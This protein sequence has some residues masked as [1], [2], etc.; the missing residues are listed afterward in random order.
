MSKRRHLNEY[1][2][3]LDRV[4]KGERAIPLDDPKNLGKRTKF[5]G[6]AQLDSRRLY[7]GVPRVRRGY[8]F[9]RSD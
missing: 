7:T 4:K 1:H 5:G 3:K 2:V 6:E 9:R 8:G